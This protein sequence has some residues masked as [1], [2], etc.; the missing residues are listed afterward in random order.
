MEKN[1]KFRN[2]NN[3]ILN[4]QDVIFEIILRHI[5]DLIYV[6][7]V[8]EDNFRYVFMNEMA[9]SRARIAED[10][11]GKTFHEALPP[12]IA[13]HLWNQ[14]QTVVE[15]KSPYLFEDTISLPGFGVIYGESILTPILDESGIIQFV[16]CV[17]R[18]VTD[19]VLEKRELNEARQMYKSLLDNNMDAIF[20]V[21]LLGKLLHIN[22]ATVEI[23]GYLEDDLVETSIFS[24]F[25]ESDRESFFNIFQRTVQ[26]RRD[27]YVGFRI[28]HKNGQSLTVHIK[29]IPI[30][31]DGK[32]HGIYA[33]FRDITE[34]YHAEAMMKYLA[35]HDQLT[36]LPN[37]SSLKT[38]LPAAVKNAKESNH[39]LALMYIDLDR[40]KFLNDTMGH[41]IGDL[42]LKEV[43]ER[44][45]SVE[46]YEKYSIYRQGGD[47]F[48][49]MLENTTRT[50]TMDCANK[51]LDKLKAA[52]NY[53]HHEFFVS[54]SIGISLYPTDG[55][56][57]DTLI[58]NADTA[59]YL[60][61]DRGR[62]HF[63]F[64]SD[65]MKQGNTKIMEMETALRRAI[66]NEELILY[67]QP[68]FDLT[69]GVVDGFEALIRWQHPQLGIISP[70]EFISLAED[71]GLI[72]PIGE[73]VI[74][75]VCSTLKKWHEQ[76]LSATT[77]AI[78]LSPRQ[79]QQV[80]LVQFIQEQITSNNIHPDYLEFEITE[81]AIQDSKEALTI[82]KQLKGLGVR[83]AVDDFG[84]GFSSLS[85][86]KK[87]PIDTL[88]ID[89]SFVKDVL[90]D[91]KD[92]AII[93]TIIHLAHSLGLMVIAEGVEQLEQ[94][95]LLRNKK[96]HKAQGYYFSRPIPEDMVIKKYL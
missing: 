12:E 14:Y 62:G 43:A 73:W 33:I 69:S 70:I 6:M 18:N 67:Y 53:A 19:S 49:V 39:Q 85:Y 63:R 60:V 25:H 56:D 34:Q 17:T 66:E 83:I 35:F 68:Q 81:G 9:L 78:N 31:V 29:T 22:P 24:L 37:R 7:K 32:V 79:F 16:V 41:D 2:S 13:N 92:E 82:L 1:E 36:G 88:K 23:T 11:I 90:N 55:E 75:K 65:Q 61:K 45:L 15:T 91:D 26:G 4:I 3:S 86:L 10:Y 20:S 47:E 64:Y 72:L 77:I 95:E 51:I 42:L 52:F 71:T 80:G 94:L 96:C 57:S 5:N 38:N 59:L 76:G 93:T 84:T 27:E 89:Q 8:E 44:L 40:F 30:V 28:K 21:D 87:Y 74:K 54:A 48:I 50:L 58:K 46:G